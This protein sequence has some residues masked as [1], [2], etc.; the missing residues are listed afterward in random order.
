MPSR[1]L[2]VVPTIYAA[3]ALILALS[4]CADDERQE[5]KGGPSV[6]PHAI[7]LQSAPVDWPSA[8]SVLA[9]IPVTPFE[10][11]AYPAQDPWLADMKAARHS[12]G[13]DASEELVAKLMSSPNA[14][15]QATRYGV[16]LTPEEEHDYRQRQNWIAIEQAI[17]SV[18]EEMPGYAGSIVNDKKR[19]YQLTLLVKTDHRP[20]F[21]DLVANTRRP[22]P[23]SRAA[24]ASMM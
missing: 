15:D 12:H 18:A 4:G 5:A 22:S 11:G 21:E 20:L 8:E 16:V 14:Q 19:D 9:Q 10:R 7:P 1:R 6:D 13:L 24:F 3:T 23:P 17:L 2:N